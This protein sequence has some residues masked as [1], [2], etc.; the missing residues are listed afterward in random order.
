MHTQ[1]IEELKSFISEEQIETTEEALYDA[2]ADRYKKYPKTK[3]VLDVPAPIAIVYP[4]S[5]EE[6]KSLLMYL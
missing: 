1:T 2:S 3:K 4:Y 6:V 5:T